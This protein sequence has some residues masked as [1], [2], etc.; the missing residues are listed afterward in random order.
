[1]LHPGHYGNP[2]VATFEHR[3]LKGRSFDERYERCDII[4][5][6]NVQPE[7]LC[8]ADGYDA[9]SYAWGSSHRSQ[10]LYIGDGGV[11]G[12][13]ESLFGALQRFR[14][15][16][17]YRR[18]WADAVCIHQG[19]LVEKA[20]Q[21]AVMHTIYSGADMVLV[22]LGRELPRDVFAFGLMHFYD[23]RN[24]SRVGL[25]DEQI[26]SKLDEKLLLNTSKC[27]C[28]EQV[29]DRTASSPATEG[30]LGIADLL[31]RSWFTRLWVVQEVDHRATV[32]R[33]FSGR[34]SVPITDFI[35]TTYLLSNFLDNGTERL[36]MTKKAA[37]QAGDTIGQ[38]VYEYGGQLPTT[39][40][41]WKSFTSFSRRLCSD[42][43]DR[44]YAIRSCLGLGYIDALT[45]DYSIGVEECF[46]RVTITMLQ[47]RNFPGFDPDASPASP[48]L[49]APW[50]P[51]SIVGTES[52]SGQAQGTRPSWV[53]DLH[54]LSERSRAKLD[55]MTSSLLYDNEL[56]RSD[57][58]RFECEIDPNDESRIRIRGRCF[59]T[60]GTP[61]VVTA[62]PSIEIDDFATSG[63][64]FAAIDHVVQW[65]IQ[66]KDFVLPSL[67]AYSDTAAAIFHDLLICRTDSVVMRASSTGP[68]N[69]VAEFLEAWPLSQRDKA[70]PGLER[71]LHLYNRTYLDKG[72][73]LCTIS[74][75]KDLVDVAWVPKLSR[76]GDK[77]FAVA[78][79][80]FP[81]VVRPLA[82]GSF[83]LLG[84][85]FT[86]AGTLAQALG[87]DRKPEMKRL[88]NT[89][90]CMSW[91]AKN[92]E[93][94][95]LMDG[96][97]WITIS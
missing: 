12:I 68:E 33:I 8:T 21:V 43:R 84:D 13:T 7:A 5:R 20:A 69:V 91:N 70:K 66:C 60:L 85:A 55:A 74:G 25:D 6:D 9:I 41:F 64:D 52:T 80:P 86:A 44:V 58:R 35:M 15:P 29:S 83:K 4:Q 45:P 36:G 10:M 79:A 61:S 65:Y 42:P 62:W 97:G 17:E 77:L 50:I 28:C 46:R 78:G 96:L 73:L 72:R 76:S 51:L 81:M 30:L 67:A 87:G 1:M 39:R 26:L 82:D 16:T 2:L 3:P 54:N 88:A 11:I 23:T 49:R 27:P 38:V 56:Y 37:R 94:V 75:D 92:D 24:F 40:T 32:G 34:H 57:H 18:L 63:T 47:E 71:F 48:P 59:A 53:P 22:W 90:E 95:A 93:M 31:T 89:D 19:D 14:S